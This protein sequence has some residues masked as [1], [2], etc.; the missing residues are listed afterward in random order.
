MPSPNA[1][2]LGPFCCAISGVMTCQSFSKSKCRPRKARR[3]STT[4]FKTYNALDMPNPSQIRYCSCHLAQCLDFT[5][6]LHLSSCRFLSKTKLRMPSNHS[7]DFWNS[8]RLLQNVFTISEHHTV[9]RVAFLLSGCSYWFR[10]QE[11]VI[12]CSSN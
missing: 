1:L 12:S 2:M 8:P 4:D 9:L 3:N 5:R 10:E 7:Y 6:S 11:Q